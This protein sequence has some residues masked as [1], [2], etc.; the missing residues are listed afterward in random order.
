MVA[1]TY[2]LLEPQSDQERFAVE[3][4]I[5]HPIQN[6]LDGCQRFVLLSVGNRDDVDLFGVQS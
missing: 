6:T 5:E 3:A 2:A 4:M 1:S